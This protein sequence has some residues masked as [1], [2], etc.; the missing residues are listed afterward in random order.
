MTTDQS[1]PVTD[2]AAAFNQDQPAVKDK[3]QTHSQDKPKVLNQTRALVGLPR[4]MMAACIVLLTINS[5]LYEGVY[6]NKDSNTA[7]KPKSVD[8]EEVGVLFSLTFCILLTAFLLLCWWSFLPVRKPTSLDICLNTGI[9][10]GGFFC[11][12]PPKPS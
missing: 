5:D 11:G 2:P 12:K 9:V 6:Y 8:F 7:K 3:A 10:I 1:Q 4:M